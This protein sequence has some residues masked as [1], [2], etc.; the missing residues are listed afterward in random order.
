[1]EERESSPRTGAATAAALTRDCVTATIGRVFPARVP[2]ARSYTHGNRHGT[3]SDKQPLLKRAP[4]HFPLALPT[5]LQ[6]TTHRSIAPSLRHRAD[7][8][9]WSLQKNALH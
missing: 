4:L 3:H 7:R 9:R 5:T 6:V 8:S 1:M 2:G